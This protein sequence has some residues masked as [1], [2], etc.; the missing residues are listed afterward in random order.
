MTHVREISH[1]EDLAPLDGQWDRLLSATPGATFFQTWQ[2][3]ETYWRHYGANQRLKLL[4]VESEGRPEAIVPLVVRSETSW[5]GPVRALTYPLDYWG[6]FF[7]PLGNN[8][9]G[10]WRAVTA[11]L[12]QQ[13]PSDWDV[14]DLRWLDS[15]GAAGRAAAE[16]LREVGWNSEVAPHATVPLIELHHGWPAYW[17]QR[18]SR[19][20]SSVHRAARRLAETGKVE[21]LRW[22]PDAAQGQA[23]C[24]WDLYDACL[25]VALASRH[26][27][28]D[29]G[30]GLTHPRGGPFLRELHASAAALGQVDVCLLLVD[31]RPAAFNYNYHR[32]GYVCGLRRAFDPQFSDG[33]GSVLM[34]RMIEDS[35][36]RGDTTIDLGP[37]YLH[38]KRYWQTTA[39]ASY[40]C[41]HYPRFNPRAQALHLGRWVRQWL[42]NQRGVAKV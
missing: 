38:T 28:G 10:A 23:N 4:V 29:H 5:L 6:S 27:V 2:W 37:D 24:R 26:V 30:V 35:A 40:R 33:A 13:Q 8:P 9:A 14:C 17:S 22:R 3:L 20:R 39:R 36:A 41:L 21:F 25:Q 11:Y 19:F 12:A 32:G 7:S 42:T 1:V 18:K 16:A 31:G 34:Q 15:D